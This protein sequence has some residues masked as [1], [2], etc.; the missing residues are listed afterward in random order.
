MVIAASGVSL[1][2]LGCG[3]G[4]PAAPAPRN[5]L[6][7]DRVTYAP[8]R[9]PLAAV[10]EVGETPLQSSSPAVLRDLDPGEPGQTVAF[11][12]KAIHPDD[13]MTGG[14]VFVRLYKRDAQGELKVANESS[15]SAT[16]SAGQLD[17][18]VEVQLPKERFVKYRVKLEFHGLKPGQ[19]ADSPPEMWSVDLAEGELPVR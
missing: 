14:L 15:A 3:G 4:Q 9:N 8:P 16:G 13:R 2:A 5:G 19:R 12:G 6:S 11:V 17:Y 1:L 10:C 7:L 18:R